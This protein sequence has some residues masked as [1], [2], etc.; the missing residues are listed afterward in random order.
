[1]ASHDGSD[2][3][4]WREGV[5]LGT[6]R[7]DAMLS[8]AAWECSARCKPPA[9]ERRSCVQ[10]VSMLSSSSIGVC[11]LDACVLRPSTRTAFVFLEQLLALASWVTLRKLNY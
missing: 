3:E 6:E 1:M 7:G 5:A 2:A 8:C 10:D 11:M 4:S 9:W